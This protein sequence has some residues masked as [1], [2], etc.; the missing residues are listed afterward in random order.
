VNHRCPAENNSSI[1]RKYTEPRSPE[2][3]PSPTKTKKTQKNKKTYIPDLEPTLAFLMRWFSCLRRGWR[4]LKPRKETQRD[5]VYECGRAER[6]VVSAWTC[7]TIS[8]L[9]LNCANDTSVTA[10]P[11][12]QPAHNRVST[13]S[14]NSR[15]LTRRSSGLR[16]ESLGRICKRPPPFNQNLVLWGLGPNWWL[17]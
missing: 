8:V 5:S 13:W 1:K 6:P 17:H 14:G 2:F 7:A 10:K 3:K 16:G 4:Q 12:D 9:S 15:T 11:D